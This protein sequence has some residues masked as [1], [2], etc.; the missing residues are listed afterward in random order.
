MNRLFLIILALALIVFTSCRNPSLEQAIIDY[1]GNRMDKA[2]EAILKAKEAVPQDPEMWYYYGEIVGKKGNIKEMVE[3]FDKSM[4]FGE[5]F[6]TKVENTKNFYFG[7]YYNDGVANFNSTLKI[8]DKESEDSKKLYNRMIDNFEKALTIKEDFQARRLIAIGYNNIGD[9]ENQ[10]KYLMSTSE[11]FPDTV[12]T[13][14]DL[15]YFYFT[16]N[17]P[18]KAV[19]YMEKAAEVDDKNAEAN[20]M[21]AQLYDGMG[22]VEKA[23]KAYKKAIEVNPEDKAIPFNLGLLLYKKVSNDSLDNEVHR[24]RLEE[25]AYYF[26]KALELDPELIDVYGIIS[27]AYINLEQYDKAEAVLKRGLELFPDSY[28]IWTNLSVLY[29]REGK[30]KE[31]QEAEKRAKALQ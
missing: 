8:E 24:N 23:I 5:A 17:E 25:S 22:L 31:A 15:G 3:A 6:K 27:A 28:A 4:E 1:N 2:Y 14:L 26:E 13:W 12:A 16:K 21:I 19:K 18:E 10:L 9:K 20:T 30:K 29:A 7:K 11:V